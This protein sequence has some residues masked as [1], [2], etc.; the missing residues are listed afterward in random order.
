MLFV[1]NVKVNR[2]VLM[3][4]AQVESEGE[5]KGVKTGNELGNWQNYNGNRGLALIID[6]VKESEGYDG[7]W[8]V[9]QER[10]WTREVNEH[11]EAKGRKIA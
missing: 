7:R 11:K 4:Q 6:E 1:P 8:K 3:Q 2:E 10:D 5:D 9:I